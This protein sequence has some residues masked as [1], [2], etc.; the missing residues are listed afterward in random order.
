MEELLKKIK[1][2][3]EQAFETIV[4]TYEKQLLV[5]AELRIGDAYLAKDAVQET[6]LSLYLNSWKIKKSSKL[7]SWLAIVL[8]SKCNNILENNKFAQISLE[9]NELENFIYS[10]DEFENVV[11]NLDFK[12]Y[13]SCLDIDERTIIAMYY[14]DNYT[15]KEISNIL[16]I[17]QGTIKSKISRAKIKLKNRTRGEISE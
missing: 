6:F 12:K 1:F 17:S 15:T 11:E 16:H 14:D 7:K 2:G 13:I 10:E 4:K 3:D 9:A 5:I 8:V